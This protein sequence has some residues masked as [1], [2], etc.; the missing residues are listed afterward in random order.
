[1]DRLSRTRNLPMTK[2]LR[3]Q[4]AALILGAALCS[5]ATSEKE[6]EL[7][8]IEMPRDDHGQMLGCSWY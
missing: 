6:P 8:L 1:M 3:E 4:G 5:C 7:P 2:H